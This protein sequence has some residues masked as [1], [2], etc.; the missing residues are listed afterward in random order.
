MKALY[1]SSFP[2]SLT[3]VRKDTQLLSKRSTAQQIKQEQPPK[4]TNK[5]YLFRA[6]IFSS[7]AK[8]VSTILNA[9]STTKI[10]T[11]LAIIF[12]FKSHIPFVVV[13]FPMLHGSHH[14]P[15]F[16]S[17][18]TNIILIPKLSHKFKN[19]FIITSSLPQETFSMNNKMTK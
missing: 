12:S 9:N 3:Y 1:L 16:K 11:N 5:T 19:K 13:L 10:H 8:S 14:S 6:F 7:Q 18:T 2:L 4:K 15:P 17:K